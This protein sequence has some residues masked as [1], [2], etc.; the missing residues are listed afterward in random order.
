MIAP[1]SPQ[2]IDPPLDEI[3][4]RIEGEALPGL[5]DS[6]ATLGK[7]RKDLFPLRTLLATAQK[8]DGQSRRRSEAANGLEM[9]AR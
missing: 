7:C 5:I 3:L 8:R 1:Q 4:E 2:R 6:N 9:L